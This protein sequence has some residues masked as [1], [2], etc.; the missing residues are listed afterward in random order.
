MSLLN[1]KVLRLDEEIQSDEPDEDAISKDQS[2]Y[3]S[4]PSSPQRRSGVE[5]IIDR[6]CAR[7][8]PLWP[9][10]NFVAVNPFIGLQE[11]HFQE[12]SDTLARILGH[13]I[14]LSRDFYREHMA[15]GR[16][17]RADIQAA[18]D[19]CACDLTIEEVE[20]TLAE[21]APRPA[22][23]MVPVSQ[24]LEAVEG[25]LWSSFVTERI[26]LHCAAYFDLGQ[27]TIPTPWRDQSLFTAWRKAAAIDRSP[28]MMGI[29][30]FRN[31]VSAIPTSARDAIAWGIAQLDIPDEAIERYLHAS[32]LSIGGWAAWTRYLRWQAE[33]NG[34]QDD[35]IIDLLAI[36]VMWDILLFREKYSDALNEQWCAMLQRSMRQPS[37]K[38]QAAARI[39]RVMLNAMEH[40][41]QRRLVAALRKPD[42]P[43]QTEGRPLVQAAFCIDV[44]SEIF[45]RSLELVSPQVQ[46]LGFAGFFG[47]FV[48]YV[49]LGADEGR[50]HVPVLFK[51]IHRVC[52]QVSE[53]T[54]LNHKVRDQRRNRIALSKTW[55]GFKYSAS[56]AFSFVEA[57]GLLYLPKLL[58]DSLGWTRP[59]P[60]PASQGLKSTL[61]RCLGP[62]L[63]R[64]AANPADMVCTGIPEQERVDHA[65]RILR[66][67][68]LTGQFARLVL[69]AGHGSRSVNN[70]H[71]S[72][73]DCG[74]C[75]GQTGEVSA[76]VVAALLNLSG[77]RAGLRERGIEIP[78]DTRF[79]AGLHDTTADSFE[80]FDTAA[81]PPALQPDVE[82]LKL[83]LQ[84]AGELTRLQRAERL[85]IA[86]QQ[87]ETEPLFTRRTR[88][89][90]QVRPEWALS[91]NAGFIAAPRSLTR[92][93]D[94]QG[95]AFLH[96]Y[97]WRDDEDF[98]VL[99][100]I[101]TAP[102]VVAN[103]INM[104]YY[105]SVVDNKTLGSGNKVLHNIVGGA[106]G[107][108]EGNGG[109]LRVGLPLQSL[110]DGKRWMHEPIRLSAFIAAPKH[111][112][113][114][115]ILRHKNVRE[116]VENHWLH[117][118]QIDE[119]GAVYRRYAT[120][121]WRRFEI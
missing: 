19:F 74:A 118:F 8:A 82:R 75:A 38:R 53:K 85:G 117:L 63:E 108:L 2:G 13:G 76:R 29:G 77:V 92:A 95:R 89:W 84:Q 69:L 73:L 65:E 28:A 97:K 16:I 1:A 51:P 109:D 70:P 115:I 72:S 32:L 107:V 24:I 17:T 90:S 78:D 96:D 15:S 91:N 100:L 22:L 111:A 79:I 57:A 33:L 21:R 61:L 49:P 119:D 99:E 88:D 105:G 58:S 40:G 23:G 60:D 59:V 3:V 47:I 7:I 62:S 101:M 120:G 68:G 55:K 30:D 71:A 6:A 121:D 98:R 18:I 11:M 94:L 50:S 41:Y 64:D 12:A 9:L 31:A 35:N 87:G 116:L 52:E 54:A 110:H 39:D 114:D 36:R 66:A 48:E 67:M 43:V 25:G 102:M 42:T 80:L 4:V 37:E 34:E 46:T 104:Q 113:D 83:W 56:S 26:S 112:M 86:A 14:Y 5:T 27:A 10:K 45:R 103:W 106:I 44:R 20:R 81:V 93:A